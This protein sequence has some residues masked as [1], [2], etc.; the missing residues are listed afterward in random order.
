MNAIIFT[1][2]TFICTASI[3]EGHYYRRTTF[4]RPIPPP[5]VQHRVILSPITRVLFRGVPTMTSFRRGETVYP[6]QGHGPFYRPNFPANIN[7]FHPQGL[8]RPGQ[9]TP[10]P[11]SQVI[12]PF[13]VPRE[14]RVNFGDVSVMGTPALAGGAPSFSHLGINSNTIL[15]PMDINRNAI[16]QDF[17]TSG[18]GIP[19]TIILPGE[20]FGLG[21]KTSNLD[22]DG[23]PIVQVQ[24]TNENQNGNAGSSDVTS[25]AEL[26]VIT[27]VVITEVSD[28][29][30]T[31]TDHGMTFPDVAI[32]ATNQ[33]FP[34][35]EVEQKKNSSCHTK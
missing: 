23:K 26:P 21:F 1:A 4:V 27:P 12:P 15:P 32:P 6:T 17:D 28:S 24:D 31:G 8:V 18:T 3:S 29:K 7:T 9:I 33:I 11:F 30:L 13:V 16:I 25:G 2:V 14:G 34:G 5:M 35:Q 19:Q 10:T 20:G 22:I